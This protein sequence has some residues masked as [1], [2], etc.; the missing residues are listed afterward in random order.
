MTILTTTT[1]GTTPINLA[2]GP[3][4]LQPEPAQA[5]PWASPPW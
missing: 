5:L 1:T 3:I 2:E 4:G